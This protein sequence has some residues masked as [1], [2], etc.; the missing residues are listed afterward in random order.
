MTSPINN[1][2]P[3]PPPRQK[4]QPR[5]PAPPSEAESP[6]G[7]GAVPPDDSD[8]PVVVPPPP[9][10][11]ATS[12]APTRTLLEKMRD[13]DTAS[14]PTDRADIIAEIA[15]DNG[16]PVALAFVTERVEEAV[17]GQLHAHELGAVALHLPG[18]LAS[19][20]LVTLAL[21]E[22][23]TGANPEPDVVFRLGLG[24]R[25]AHR[26]GELVQLEVESR[27]ALRAL[28][29]SL[30]RYKSSQQ[31]RITLSCAGTQELL[32]DLASGLA[33]PQPN[34]L[35]RRLGKAITAVFT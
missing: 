14:D 5:H 32:D 26:R 28:Q 11:A 2:S 10:D 31:E 23:L 13:F 6:A 27:L 25:D 3:D 7:H 9:A 8:P 35:Y 15:N 34:S 24:I 18:F 20:P 17:Q 19:C 4:R 12:P 21:I 29:A 33:S 30:A 22:K 1:T 16:D